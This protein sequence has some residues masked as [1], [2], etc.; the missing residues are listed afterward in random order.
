MR[1]IAVIALRNEITYLANCLQHLIDNGIDYAVIDNDSAD[2]SA[3]LVKSSRF[4]RNLVAFETLPF[5]GS[6]N[7]VA[8]LE[9]KAELCKVLDADWFL[10]LDADEIMH[11]RRDGE[12]LAAG[13]ARLS[14]TGANIIN[15]E[16]FVFLPV[17]HSY[18]PDWPVC[19]PMGYYYFF[20]P[21]PQR[22]HRVWRAGFTAINAEKGGHELSGEGL[23]IAT[24]NFVLRH[25]IFVDQ[26]HAYR[27]Y[28]NRTFNSVECKRGWH[29]NRIGYQKYQY[30]MP[31]KYKLQHLADINHHALSR[32]DP[33]NTHYWEWDARR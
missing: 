16:E 2:G 8:Q 5:D 31:P 20:A 3:E 27:K 33:K 9:K 28:T 4:R 19:Q 10:H 14:E 23:Q 6:F 32:D 17:E 1:A 22:L 11:S 13:I 26:A 7:L 24:E 18:R 12:T 29:R 30:T 15:F 25:Y 21:K